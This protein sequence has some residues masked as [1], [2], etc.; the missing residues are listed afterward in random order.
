MPLWEEVTTPTLGGRC[1]R[2]EGCYTTS[3]SRCGRSTMPCREATG[4]GWEANTAGRCT[5]LGVIV[6]GDRNSPEGKNQRR[7]RRRG[8]STRGKKKRR[9]RKVEEG[10]TDE[11][12]LERPTPLRSCNSTSWKNSTLFSASELYGLMDSIS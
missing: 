7:R 3:G 1:G 5:R 9:K 6:V 10:G 2:P 4:L 12:R 8:K 11:L